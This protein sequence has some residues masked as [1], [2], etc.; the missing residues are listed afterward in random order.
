MEPGMGMEAAARVACHGLVLGVAGFSS[1]P[2]F[3]PEQLGGQAAG[4]GFTLV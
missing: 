2:G 4:C 3:V 1:T